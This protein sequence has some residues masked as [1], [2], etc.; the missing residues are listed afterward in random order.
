MNAFQNAYA[1]SIKTGSHDIFS[2][3]LSVCLYRQDNEPVITF[4]GSMVPP[5]PEMYDFHVYLLILRFHS[6]IYST[7]KFILISI[8][9][10]YE[11][12][13]VVLFRFSVQN[14]F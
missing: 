8:V 5:C 12:L 1:E 7:I 4:F 2:A 10:E 9:I 6:V 13:N 3:V 11:R 14:D